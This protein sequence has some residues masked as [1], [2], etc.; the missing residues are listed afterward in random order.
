[1]HRVRSLIPTTRARAASSPQRIL[2]IVAIA[3]ALASV[4]SAL[5]RFSDHDLVEANSF[6]AATLLAPTDLG[7]TPGCDLVLLDPKVDLAWT[8]SA[9]PK[10][11]G[12]KVLRST[13]SGGPY[14][15]VGSVLGLDLTSFTDLTVNLDTTYY[16]VVVAYFSGWTSVPTAEVAATTPLLC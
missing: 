11:D 14:A 13:T 7:A 1:M 8:A 9:S 5:A 10:G 15:E 16:Y 3:L 12:Y 6:A 2:L 4:G